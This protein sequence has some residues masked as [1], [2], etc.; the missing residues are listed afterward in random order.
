VSA[1]GYGV[2]RL[3]T[4]GHAHAR[5]NRGSSSTPAPS[6]TLAAGGTTGARLIGSVPLEVGHVE[7][8]V[9]SP[10]AAWLSSWTTG[11]LTRI[12]GRAPRV[13]ARVRIGR[14][15][16]G[17]LSIA[18]GAD[19]LWVIDAAINSLIDL[20][21]TQGR[22]R[23]TLSLTRWGDGDTVAYG[24]QFLW[25]A[26][27]GQLG[28]AGPRERLLKVDPAT[29]QVLGVDPLPGEGEDLTVLADHG[30]VWVGGATRLARINVSTGRPLAAH[31]T[32]VAPIALNAGFLWTYVHG[33]LTEIDA[34]TGHVL[35]VT[36]VQA[37]SPAEADALAVDP[38]GRAWT[39]TPMLEMIR[40]TGFVYG[41]S[42]Y[43]GPV[44]RLA[45]DGS[46]LWIYTGRRVLAFDI[47]HLNID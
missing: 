16:S 30:D 37:A 26:C 28:G 6:P 21:P 2:I 13:T 10:G 27:S 42:Q 39:P 24:A 14:P 40:P 43:H 32:A 45:V 5:A 3:S 29:L 19:S 7:Q 23:R 8:I 44:E 31:L 47:M 20:D 25:I 12:A 1:G 15:Q 33:H 38:S 17:P 4:R 35:A 34:H 46:S 18:Y 9:L 22:Q 11:T 36:H 41:F